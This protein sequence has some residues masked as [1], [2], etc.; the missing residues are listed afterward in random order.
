MSKQF[1]LTPDVAP[2]ENEAKPP[3]SR[4]FVPFLDPPQ[5]D[6]QVGRSL[7]MVEHLGKKLDVIKGQRKLYLEYFNAE[8]QEVER[9]LDIIRGFL[10]DYAKRNKEETGRA[11]VT[12][13]EGRV[14]YFTQETLDVD[15]DHP[16]ALLWARRYGHTVNVE[17]IVKRDAKKTLKDIKDL[18][19]FVERTQAE[20][21]VV[22]TE[23]MLIE[24]VSE[25]DKLLG[26]G[27]DELP[28]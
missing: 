23:P 28:F 13:P 12:I 4:P 21:L 3:M 17:H 18:P 22:K 15:W 25:M 16:E 26:S 8:I 6:W 9:K 24:A 19:Q 7:I 5:N 1:S 27:D 20:R 2:L 11:S 14:T 10:Q